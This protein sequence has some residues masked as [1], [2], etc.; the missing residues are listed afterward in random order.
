MVGSFIVIAMV[1]LL[2]NI[3]INY[4][5]VG[6]LC[7]LIRIRPIFITTF[8]ILATIV[9]CVIIISRGIKSWEDTKMREEIEIDIQNIAEEQ[10]KENKQYNNLIGLDYEKQKY[11]EPYIPDGFTYIEGN[12]NTGYVIQD[13]KGNQYV[14]V[15]CTNKYIEGVTKLA[16][17]NFVYNSYMSKDLCYDPQCEEFIKSALTNG[18]YYISRFEIGRDE[19]NNAISKNNTRIWNNINK[20]EAI[21]VISKINE[22]YEGVTIQLMNSYSYDTAFE[23]ILNT[24]NEVKYE[25]IK[26]DDKGN[27]YSGTKCYNNI[28]DLFD[29]TYEITTEIYNE[30]RTICRGAAG[31]YNDIMNENNTHRLDNRTSLLWDKSDNLGFRTILYK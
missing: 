28:Y 11:D 27:R 5:R 7:S 20:E 16:K 9:I 25:I 26:S 21:E 30:N 6:E 2:I 19:N 18:G 8:Q 23:W 3:I 13:K 17:R 12:W 10:K 31:I 24:N 14:W 22:L 4:K 1:I 29:T 15:P